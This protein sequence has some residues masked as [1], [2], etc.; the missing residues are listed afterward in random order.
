[1]LGLLGDSRVLELEVK[2]VLE[3]LLE[4]ERR[5]ESDLLFLVQDP[6][7]DLPPHAARKNDEPIAELV[8]QLPIDGRARARAFS[9][10]GCIDVGFS[11]HPAEIAV[12]RKILAENDEVM[13]LGKLLCTHRLLSRRRG[14]AR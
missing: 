8:Q 10:W 11:D 3:S 7:G 9:R 4:P 14:C 2:I 5:L 12:A 13:M 1:D 6:P